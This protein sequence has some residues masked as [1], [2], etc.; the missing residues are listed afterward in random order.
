M[1]QGKCR[2]RMRVLKQEFSSNNWHIFPTGYCV[3]YQVLG[4]SSYTDRQWTKGLVVHGN[5]SSVNQPLHEYQSQRLSA[6]HVC[7]L[8]KIAICTII[9]MTKMQHCT[10]KLFLKIQ[11]NFIAKKST[12]IIHQIK[13]IYI[14]CI[15]DIEIHVCV[16]PSS[17]YKS[18]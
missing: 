12:S 9:K 15:F 8:R 10:K 3:T 4:Q 11:E 18:L 6:G 16:H 7:N 17:S 14:S 5:I 2:R 1:P 13:H